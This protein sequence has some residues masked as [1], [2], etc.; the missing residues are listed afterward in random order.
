M[1]QPERFGHIFGFDGIRIV[2]RRFTIIYVVTPRHAVIL[3]YGSGDWVCQLLF[4]SSHL[5][6]NDQKRTGKKRKCIWIIIKNQ[7]YTVYFT[8]W[9]NTLCFTQCM[10]FGTESEHD[11]Y[12]PAHKNSTANDCILKTVD[13][14]PRPLILRTFSAINYFNESVGHRTGTHHLANQ[15]RQNEICSVGKLVHP[16]LNLSLR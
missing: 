7:S 12:A 15:L 16:A 3:I 8:F 9:R 4:W 2:T 13:A 14:R 1:Y 5:G 6:G 10:K 11:V